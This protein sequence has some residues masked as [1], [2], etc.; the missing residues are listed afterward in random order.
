MKR[1]DVLRYMV[2]LAAV[3][4][5]GGGICNPDAYSLYVLDN[6]GS[7]EGEMLD[8][9]GDSFAVLDKPGE[10]RLMVAHIENFYALE[11][12]QHVAET[13]LGQS[14]RDCTITRSHVVTPRQIE[15]YYACA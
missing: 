11:H 8:V 9:G 1:T 6:Y 15:F 13:Y 7:V 2:V 14:G 3:L 4:V 5:L 10:G 12:W